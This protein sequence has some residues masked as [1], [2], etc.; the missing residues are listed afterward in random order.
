MNLSTPMDEALLDEVVE[1]WR[2]AI[3]RAASAA[4]EAV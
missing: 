1:R 2:R 3:D 4:S